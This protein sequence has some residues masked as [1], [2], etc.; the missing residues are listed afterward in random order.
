MHLKYTTYIVHATKRNR[1]HHR[2]K[3]FIKP[4]FHR[5]RT[6]Q[7]V[8]IDLHKYS[9]QAPTLSAFARPLRTT[10]LWLYRY[11]L[12]RSEANIHHGDRP[13]TIGASVG[14]VC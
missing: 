6:Y 10:V 13:W 14:R 7:V 11:F 2:Q 5:L 4:R 12:S 3:Y 8:Q 9:Q 1:L